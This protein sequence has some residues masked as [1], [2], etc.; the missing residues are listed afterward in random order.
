MATTTAKAH[1]N[2]AVALAAFQAEVPSVG[3]SKTANVPTKSGGSYSYRYA[4]LA[5]LTAAAFPLLVKHGLAFTA[6]PR[7]TEGGGY[8]LVGRLMHT[9]GESI[10]GALPLFGRTSQEIGSSITY[11]RRYLIGCLTGLVTD[12]DDDGA[13]SQGARTT[14]GQRNQAA[15]PDWD[16]VLGTASGI[17]DVAVLRDLWN[18]ENLYAAPQEVRDAFQ[19]HVAAVT[20]GNGRG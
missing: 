16:A 4:D 7:L 11:N 15:S 12:D 20:S 1:E 3:K 9:S 5:D 10:E 6:C 13:A 18:R 17:T 19:Q 14:R 8:E 2:L